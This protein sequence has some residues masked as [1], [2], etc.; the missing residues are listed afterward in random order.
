MGNEVGDRNKRIAKN[1]LYLYLR[2]FLMMA[3]SLYTSR[4]VL[5][6]LGA[7]DYGIYNVVGGV[8][9]MFGIISASLA[10]AIS[11]FITFELGR[12][13]IARLK[14]VFSTAVTI[15][16]G[17]AVVVCILA[18]LIAVW[19]LNTRMNIP[20]ERMQA[21][22]WV[23]Q[24]SIFTFMVNL[25]SVPYNAAIIAHE[26][27]N[28]FAYISLLEAV[29]KLLIVY[30]LY[31]WGFDKL[32]LY[33]VLLLMVALIIRLVYGIYCKRKFV[34]CTYHF[35]YDKGI[36]KEMTGF[37]GWNFIGSSSAILRDQGGNVILNLFH[38]PIVN[39]A[40]GISVQVN[41]AVQSFS[42]NFIM[43]LR[44]QIIKSYAQG[45][46]AY[47]FTLL[48]QGAR[49]SFYLLLLLSVPI[50]MNVDYLLTLWLKEF[51]DHTLRFVTLALLFTLSE[52]ISHPLITAQQAT[53]KIRDYQLVVGGLQLLNLPIAYL[54]LRL[55]GEPEVVLY[56]ALA[57]SQC[58][59][60]ARLYMLRRNIRLSVKTFLRKVYLN[61]VVVGGLSMVLSWFCT[62]PCAH[63]F[64]GFVLSCLVCLVLTLVVELFVGCSGKERAF[65]WTKGKSVVI[66]KLK[67]YDKHYR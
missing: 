62:R 36:L 37:A 4:V 16:I 11:R 67:K 15:Q 55:R 53:G 60:A 6:T 54:L 23:L 7:E 57:I 13:D 40:R 42:D 12:K 22:N 18:E 52:S 56:V 59:L 34:E 41:H 10:S 24:C 66:K 61:V 9:A 31:V 1:T 21:A 51:P 58:C 50:L 20:V 27:M 46:R 3:V 26:R 49:L 32:K 35:V 25:V 19:F 28:V 44:P 48:F 65:V 8:V 5:H 43:A 47:M 39:A 29:L 45:D 63:N 33:A 38:G 14:T 17:I 2:M 64:G 30:L